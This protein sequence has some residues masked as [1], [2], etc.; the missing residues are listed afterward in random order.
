AGKDKVPVLVGSWD[1]DQE[2]LILATLDPLSALAEADAET[3]T[4]LLA[5]VE[6]DSDAL[7]N[8]LTSLAEGDVTPFFQS[9]LEPGLHDPD[10]IPEPPDRPKTKLGDLWQLGNHRLHCGDS[11]KAEDVDRLLDGAKIHL[12]NTDPPYG[13]GVEPR[14]NNAI[15]MGLS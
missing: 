2:K 15:K 12:V 8:L 14:S 9:E 13:V 5:D 3:L 1:E 6:T 4:A 11:S 10:D 7:L